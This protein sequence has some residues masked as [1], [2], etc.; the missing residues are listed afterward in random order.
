MRCGEIEVD[1]QTH[2]DAVTQS[3]NAGFLIE[4]KNVQSPSNVG[5]GS[6]QEPRFSILA[7]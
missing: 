1:R 3:G 6:C 2:T 4:K 7:T 5:P